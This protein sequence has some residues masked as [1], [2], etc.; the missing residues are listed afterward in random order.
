VIKIQAYYRG[1]QI[2]K[3]YRKILWSVGILE[4]A[5]LRWRHKGKGL[6]GIGA[7]NEISSEDAEPESDNEEDFFKIGRKYA[8]ERVERSI[9]RVQAMYRSYQARAEYRRMKQC[10]N[11]A[12]LE[13]E[14]ILDLNLSEEPMSDISTEKL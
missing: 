1:H 13:Y 7:D 10:H 12:Q 4:K 5:I 6:R 11:Q 14:Q 2:R 8:E 9:I 3:Q